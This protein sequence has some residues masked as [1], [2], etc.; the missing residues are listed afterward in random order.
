MQGDPG[1]TEIQGSAD[2][3]P[4]DVRL[5][6]RT[7]A[8]LRAALTFDQHSASAPQPP[9]SWQ[10]RGDAGEVERMPLHRYIS[11]QSLFRSRPSGTSNVAFALTVHADPIQRD[12]MM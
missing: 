1:L 9:K 12:G 8:Q 2:M 10:R 6:R 7:L 4:L 3:G 11:Q 5:E